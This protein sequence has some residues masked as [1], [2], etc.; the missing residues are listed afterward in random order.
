MKGTKS[1][2]AVKKDLKDRDGLERTEADSCHNLVKTTNSGEHLSP[3]K[4]VYMHSKEEK[5]RMRLDIALAA[6]L[7]RKKKKKCRAKLKDTFSL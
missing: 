1:T 2:W 5:E 4:K 3:V 6:K 7:K